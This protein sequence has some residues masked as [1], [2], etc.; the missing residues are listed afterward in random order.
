MSDESQLPRLDSGRYG[1][2]ANRQCLKRSFGAA[3]VQ[4]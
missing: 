1:G 3:E 4:W 2:A